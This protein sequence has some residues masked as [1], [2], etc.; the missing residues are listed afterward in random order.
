MF[1]AGDGLKYNKDR[2]VWIGKNT[3][4]EG[5]HTATF[6]INVST[7]TSADNKAAWDTKKQL[8]LIKEQSNGKKL[9]W[10]EF[11]KQGYMFDNK[12]FKNFEATIYWRV[13]RAKWD[14]FGRGPNQ[15]TFYGRGGVHS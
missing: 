11:H 10:Q 1:S 5:G 3:S 2:K 12:D 7:T 9:S 14:D 15:M 13:T 6:R 4:G 8:E